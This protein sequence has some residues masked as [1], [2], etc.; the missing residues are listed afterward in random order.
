MQHKHLRFGASFSVVL[1]DKH[2]Q[3]A[4]MTLEPGG[5]EGGPDNRHKGADQWLFVVEGDGLAIVED[6]KVQ[7]RAG[8]LLLI[9]RGEVHEIRNTG[10]EPLRTI[11]FYVPPA[12]TEDDEELPIA[13]MQANGMQN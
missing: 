8:T 11:N 7:L 12:Y 3:A 6:Q 5:T 13:K 2:S 4:Q 10:L 9:E 1:G